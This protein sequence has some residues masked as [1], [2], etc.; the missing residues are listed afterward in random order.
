MKNI[1]TLVYGVLNRK[2]PSALDRNQFSSWL[3]GFIDAQESIGLP[4]TSVAV[5]RNID[6]GKA[7]L[8]R[9]TFYSYL[10]LKNGRAN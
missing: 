5:R 3:A 4:R 2:L 9:Y 10:P 1:T 8:N 6:T 7:Y